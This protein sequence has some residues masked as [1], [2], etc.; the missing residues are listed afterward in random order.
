M[1]GLRAGT[2]P[3][4]VA[5]EKFGEPLDVV[6]LA[7]MPEYAPEHGRVA[8]VA[9][10][11]R[12]GDVI[13]DEPLDAP[14]AVGFVNQIIPHFQRRELGNVLVFGYGQNLVFGQFRKAQTVFECQHRCRPPPAQTT[15]FLTI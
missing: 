2:Q 4:G 14:L 8:Q 13:D 1:A 11:A 3:P 5:R 6:L 9:V 12:R 10:L 15:M 7:E